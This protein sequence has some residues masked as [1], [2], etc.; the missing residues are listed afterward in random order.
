M[1]VVRSVLS[2]VAFLLVTLILAAAV[3]FHL[4]VTGQ[5]LPLTKALVARLGEVIEGQQTEHLAVD[6]RL[7]PAARRL[8]GTAQLQVR[9][10]ADGRR[11]LY[12]VLNG[13][14]RVREA[15]R[16]E[17]DGTH[18]P[19]DSYQIALI[20][21]LDL[22]H[23]HE[24]N[25]VVQVGLRYD[26]DPRAG[27]LLSGQA[28][29]DRNTVI[30]P[31]GDFWYPTNLQGFTM[32]DVTVTLP[33]RLSLVHN[34]RDVSRQNM[35]SDVRVRWATPRPVPGLALVAGRF[36]ET[37]RTAQDQ[38]HRVLLSDEIGLDPEQILTS[39]A[40]SNALFT[41][42]YG[43]SGLPGTTVF[44]NRALT[45]AFNDGSGLIGIPVGRFRGGDYGA[46]IVAH[47]V[48]HN[49]WGGT[50]GEDWLRP[51][52]G[53]AWVVGGF[54][55]F[56]SWL[57]VREQLGE[58]A[59]VRLR[60]HD[61]FDPKRTPLLSG[62]T[63]FDNYLDPQSRSAIYGKGAYVISLLRQ[64]VGD[65]AFASATRELLDRFRYAQ[66]TDRDV[67]GVFSKAAGQD[68][69]TFFAVWVRSDAM[70]DLALDASEGDAVVTNRG[71]APPPASIRLWRVPPDGNPASQDV[72]V[73]S[74]TPLG[75]TEYLILDPL[76]D[77]P[78]MYRDSNV[79]PRRPNPR[80]VERSARGELMVVY[81]EPYPWEPAA[82]THLDIAGHVLHTWEFD[83]GIEADPV[84]TAD[85]TRMLVMERDHGGRERLVV[86]NTTD[87]NRLNLR[88]AGAATGTSDAT[89]V[90]RAD[91]LV[92][93]EGNKEVPVLHRPGSELI[94]PLASPD[95]KLVAYAARNHGEMELRVA[96]TDRD[97]DRLLLTWARAPVNWVWAPDGRGLFAAL[98][99]DWD[100]QLWEIP[101]G[102]GEPRVFVREAAAITSLAPD[103]DGQRIAFLAAPDLNYG[104]EHR[105]LFII[106][107]P[108]AAVQRF[109]LETR[110]GHDVA[111]LDQN[112]LVVVVSDPVTAAAPSRRELHR[113]TLPEGRLTPFP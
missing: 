47:E 106:D 97:E 55:E 35:G 30:L 48:A 8:A 33:A 12:F 89:V 59:M 13:G 23:R 53:G 105:E 34:G 83:R 112:S 82:V 46:T 67:E 51:G 76:L 41:E 86:L 16:E 99:G 101:V 92:R 14:L 63:V 66:V 39:V 85:G 72:T 18:V 56:S 87:G 81:G 100:W 68:L 64:V 45:R 40:A 71:T 84:W 11:Y 50:V 95:G 28:V 7:R 4:A 43:T 19:L 57:A 104:N 62:L 24:S 32:A 44:L 60:A 26:G 69:S 1:R 102:G 77:T 22:G 94:A 96:R 90:A 113:L 91:R 110:Y 75:N 80:A 27:G 3:F 2:L 6:V 79:F 88:W 54:A 74:R 107:L 78:D 31:P 29:M 73:G 20:V 10:P 103:P 25:E 65:A 17:A 93:L 61:F 108:S 98:P 49:W 38:R 111:W 36:K 21:V 37:V 52:S 9:L 15:W 70:L 109:N 58:A 42:I 5:S